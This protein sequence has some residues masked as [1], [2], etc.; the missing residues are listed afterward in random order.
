MRTAEEILKEKNRRMISISPDKTVYEAIRIM[1]KHHI[2]AIVI[3]DK[4]KIVGIWTEHDL[5]KHVLEEGF[6]PKTA[7]IGDYMCTDLV[8]A[9]YRDPV[10]LLQDKY[11]GKRLRHLFVRKEGEMIGLLS[12]GDVMRASLADTAEELSKLN[13]V[14]SWEYYENW[15][16]K[17]SKSK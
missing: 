16:W 15:R 8:A 3:K 6:N 1:N 4:Q 10:P 13:A 7:K 12:A 2:G 5:M 9:D 17:R 14:C 11:L